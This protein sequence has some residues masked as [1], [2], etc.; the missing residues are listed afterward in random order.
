M[1]VGLYIDAEHGMAMVTEDHLEQWE[2]GF[3]EILEISLMNLRA[4]L[5][6]LREAR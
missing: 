5:R 4:L 3:D 1:S 6:A 2:A